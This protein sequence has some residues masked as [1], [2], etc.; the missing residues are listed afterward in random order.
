MTAC[1]SS[2]STGVTGDAVSRMH[3]CIYSS[4]VQ[5]TS[6]WPG[7]RRASRDRPRIASGRHGKSWK[8]ML[9][10]GRLVRRLRYLRRA[11]SA[12]HHQ[13]LRHSQGGDG[14]RR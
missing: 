14:R 13:V 8:P 9:S 3:S 1:C 7:Y 10:R 5:R 4:W 6:S 11:A 12:V 2:T